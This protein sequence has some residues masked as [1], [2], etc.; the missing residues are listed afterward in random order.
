MTNDMLSEE[1]RTDLIK[2]LCGATDIE[3]TYNPLACTYPECR[4]DIS[5]EG[6]VVDSEMLDELCK[7]VARL[8]APPHRSPR[9]DGT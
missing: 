5:P 3:G 6:E 9:H 4:C 7:Y 1:V 2:I 8:T